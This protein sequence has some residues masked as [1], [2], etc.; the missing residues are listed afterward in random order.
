MSSAAAI[1]QRLLQIEAESDLVI[2]KLIAE[3][4]YIVIE[5]I[6]TYLIHI[7]HLAIEK[8]Q[9]VERLR[10]LNSSQPPPASKR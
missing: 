10:N 3:K 1:N 6:E 4:D 5:A 7:A 8:K 9:L 2:N